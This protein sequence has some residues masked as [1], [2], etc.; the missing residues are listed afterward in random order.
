MDERISAIAA[1]LEAAGHVADAKRILS[2]YEMAGK[3]HTGQKRKDGE[4][5]ISHPVS[6]AEIVSD[7]GLDA[8]SIIA[9]L[10]HD[11]VEDTELTVETIKKQFG[12]P[13][14][15]LVDGMTKL[16][17]IQ[18]QSKEEEEMENLR[19]MFIAMAKDIR[20][21]LIKLADRLHNMRTIKYMGDSKQREIALETMEIYAPIAHRLGMTRFRWELEDLSLQILDAVGYREIVAFIEGRKIESREFIENIRRQTIEKLQENG[22]VSTVD[23]RVKHIY[24][25]YRK[26]Y[27][28]KKELDELY[29]IYAI[30]VIVD[31]Q[32]D[33]YNAL[34]IVHDLFKPIPGR[35]KDYISTPKP[36]MYQSLHTTVIGREGIPFE[37]QIRTW[38]MHHT[39]EYGIAAHWKYKQGL[40]G[41]NDSLDDKLDWVRHLLES[42]QDTDAEDFIKNLKTDM[43]ADAAYVFTP[44]GDVISLPAGATPVDFAYAIHSEVGN[45]MIGCKVNGK[46]VPIASIL[47]NGDIVEVI[48]SGAGKGP[49]RDWLMVAKTNQARNKIRQWY[50]KER[51][52]ENMEQGQQLLAAALKRNGLP[53][54]CLENPEVAEQLIQRF[55]FKSMDELY[56]GVG[57]GGVTVLRVVN[58][59]KEILSRT[60]KLPETDADAIEKIQQAQGKARHSESGVIVEDI[61]SV[62]V[63]FARCCTPVPGDAIVGFITRGYGVSVHRADC[64]NI[65]AL[66]SSGSEDVK[67]VIG[68]YW[69]EDAQS[70]YPTN[71]GIHASDRFGLIAD[72]AGVLANLHIM[73]ASISTR[74]FPDNTAL[75]SL[76]LQVSSKQELNGICEKL[77]AIAGVIEVS[78]NTH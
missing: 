68:V 66:I 28:Q 58:R 53:D 2:A 20:V 52:E 63:K 70:R 59:I 64:P 49:S 46:M 50:K 69:D 22:I 15:E 40:A 34:G 71:I 33:C 30:R 23:G 77:N 38:D 67:R 12:A 54:D 7:M 13:V 25:I 75:V 39:A 36:N 43:F 47:Q 51:R 3:A 9:A 72:V 61:D 55:S 24:S 8:D 42:Q 6:V 44:K 76:S 16:A 14:A 5:F 10:L 60:V 48:T 4:P 37:I 57:Y 45:R 73:I 27:S 21:I 74:K 31:T 65:I 78:R 62:K 26:A 35:F 17:S 1:R 18:Y 29:D 19:K 56:A 41:A 32:N 11:T